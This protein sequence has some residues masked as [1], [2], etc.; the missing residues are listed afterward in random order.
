MSQVLPAVRNGS[1]GCKTFY[2]QIIAAYTGWIDSRNNIKEAVV[3]AD[4]SPLPDD[5]IMDLH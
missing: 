2:N 4:D 3:F 1:N 5:I